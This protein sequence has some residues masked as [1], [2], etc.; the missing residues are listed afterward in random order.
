MHFKKS[1]TV[2]LLLVSSLV[3]GQEKEVIVIKDYFST[4]D[5]GFQTIVVHSNLELLDSTTHKIIDI[6]AGLDSLNPRMKNI[7]I[8]KAPGHHQP[9]ARIV[10]K[11]SGFFRKNK[12]VI[13]FNP[14]TQEI[15]NVVENEKVILKKKF[16]KYQEYLEDA[17]DYAELEALHP[18]MEEL[19]M[20]MELRDLP[21][22]QKIADLNAILIDLE[23]LES[24]RA[25]MKKE[26]FISIKRIIELDELSEAILGLLE[27]AGVTPPQKIEQIELKDGLF[28][29]NGD[30]I[31][32]ALG[33]KCIKAY[34]TH[35]GIEVDGDGDGDGDKGTWLEKKNNI[36]IIFD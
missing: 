9:T 33:Q 12:I 14:I 3:I 23:S 4:L 27:D 19:E 21:D 15:L 28:F 36:K 26:H 1:L 30:E 10:I 24:G 22:S 25:L 17:S 16:H 32:G 13:D 29:L 6:H 11:K 8:Q 18:R 35:T 7:F 31:K 2:L 20:I 34:N 5:S